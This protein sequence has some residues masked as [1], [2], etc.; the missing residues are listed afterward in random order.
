MGYNNFWLYDK[1]CGL[2]RIR[3]LRQNPT[4]LVEGVGG[5]TYSIFC[6]SKHV[7]MIT[8]ADI[9]E[10]E[11]HGANVF[12]FNGD[13][14]RISMEASEYAKRKGIEISPFGSVLQRFEE[15]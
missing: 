15:M 12:S 8:R 11:H 4:I 5:K 6:T 14:S 9:E 2:N 3:V 10:A 13:K 7:Y 1:L